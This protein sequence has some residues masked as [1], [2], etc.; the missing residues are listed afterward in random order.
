[1]VE[2][3]LRKNGVK[4]KKAVGGVFSSQDWS[5]KTSRQKNCPQKKIAGLVGILSQRGGGGSHRMPT[6]YQNSPKLNLPW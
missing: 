4:R 2:K 1:M 5:Q 3:K 6:F